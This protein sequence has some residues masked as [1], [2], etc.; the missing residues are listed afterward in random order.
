MPSYWPCPSFGPS[1]ASRLLCPLLTSAPRSRALRTR[2]VRDFRTRRRP[3]EVRPTALAASPPDLPSRPLMALDFAITRSLVRPGRPRIRFLFH[4]VAA[5]LHA[6]FRPRLA[7]MPLRFAN[8]SPPSGWIEDLH[9]Q[10]VGHARHTRRSRASGLTRPL[11]EAIRGFDSGFG[12]G[13]VVGS[14]AC[15]AAVWCKSFVFSSLSIR[16]GLVLN[17]CPIL[18]T[19]SSLLLLDLYYLFFTTCLLGIHFQRRIRAGGI[20]FQRRTSAGGYPLSAWK[21]RRIHTS[22]WK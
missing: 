4:R 9:L 12:L 1:P 3:P 8:P 2:S 13:F 22:L 17:F 5:L 10:A 11:A 14:L 7:T 20:H 15:T 16:K 6:S 21:T 19:G 18:S